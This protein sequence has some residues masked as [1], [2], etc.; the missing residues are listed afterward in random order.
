M[1]SIALVLTW[2]IKVRRIGLSNISNFSPIALALALSLDALAVVFVNSAFRQ[3]FK[4][5]PDSR[6]ARLCQNACF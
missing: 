1:I 4:S 3:A 5:L 2:H 6:K